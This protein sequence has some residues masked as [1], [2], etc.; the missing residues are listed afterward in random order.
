MFKP[1]MFASSAHQGTESSFS[2]LSLK[3]VIS[4]LFFAGMET[5][6]TTLKWF[7]L[8]M[9]AYPEVQSR[10]QAEMDQVVGRE[11]LPGLDDRENLPYTRAV[12]M[13]VSGVLALVKESLHYKTTICHVL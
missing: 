1:N 4:D 11:R 13:E 3:A 5:T 8:Y 9:M 10:V 7:I 6:T 2:H 12:L